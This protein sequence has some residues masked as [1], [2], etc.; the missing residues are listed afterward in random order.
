MSKLFLVVMS[1]VCPG[2]AIGEELAVER[3]ITD[4]VAP[5][6]EALPAGTS[7][8]PGFER[9]KQTMACQSENSMICQ[10][11]T[12]R[13]VFAVNCYHE[14]LDAFLTRWGAL[15]VPRKA[16]EGLRERFNAEVKA[17]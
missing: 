1:L 10:A 7:V 11:D 5:M 2:V 17:E 4:D 3:R 16:E 13:L 15:A 9:D 6:P 12:R 14:S 8:V